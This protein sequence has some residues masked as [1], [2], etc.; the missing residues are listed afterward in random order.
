MA[1]Y[2]HAIWG[3]NIV[4]FG[5]VIESASEGL[6]AVIAIGCGVVG[7]SCSIEFLACFDGGRKDAQRPD[8][9][10]RVFFRY[11]GRQIR[12]PQVTWICAAVGGG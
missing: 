9:P 6:W 4:R 7:A 11:A 8:G 12:V 10:L 1:E 3:A 5:A 2:G